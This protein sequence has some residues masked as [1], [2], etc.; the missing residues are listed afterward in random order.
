[1][2]AIGGLTIGMMTRTARG[3]TA[4]PLQAGR[5]EIASYVLVQLAAVTRVLVPLA[6]PA[7]YL[8]ATLVSAAFW[9]AAFALFFV[10]YVPMLARPRLDGQ[11]G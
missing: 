9:F 6:F 2:G 8:G 5:A 3:H 11:P 10:T 1:V 4:R 7:A